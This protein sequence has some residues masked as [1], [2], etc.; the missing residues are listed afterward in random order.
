MRAHAQHALPHP[1]KQA[2]SRNGERTLHPSPSPCQHHSRRTNP[3]HPAPFRTIPNLENFFP[4]KIPSSTG[5]MRYHLQLIAPTYAKLRNKIFARPDLCPDSL[6]PTVL[7]PYLRHAPSYPPAFCLT[8][9]CR[10]SD[11]FLTHFC[12]KKAHFMRVLTG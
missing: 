9:H 7:P 4:V 3:N 8:D 11:A 2:F 10:F 12:E 1:F 6:S 5:L